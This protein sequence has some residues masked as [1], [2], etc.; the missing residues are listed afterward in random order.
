MST[1]NPHAGHVHSDAEMPKVHEVPAAGPTA[2]DPVCS[3]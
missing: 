1:V 3:L 2:I